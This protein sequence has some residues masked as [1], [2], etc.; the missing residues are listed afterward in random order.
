MVILSVFV[1]LFGGGVLVYGMGWTGVQKTA[2]LPAV[3]QAD[4][5]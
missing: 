5:P 2:S 3:T 1:A 4:L